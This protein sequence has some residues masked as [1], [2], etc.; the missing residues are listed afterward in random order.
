M[1]QMTYIDKKP[2]ITVSESDHDRLWKLAAPLHERADDVPDQLLSELDRAE[3]VPDDKIPHGV[4][5]MGGAP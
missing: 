4:I 5:T 2:S 3:I 1:T